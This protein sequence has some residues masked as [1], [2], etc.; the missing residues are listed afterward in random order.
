[1]VSLAQ[2]RRQENHVRAADRDLKTIFGETQALLGDI[3]DKEGSHRALQEEIDYYNPSE[4]RAAFH[5]MNDLHLRLCDSIRNTIWMRRVVTDERFQRIGSAFLDYDLDS[6]CA[7][8][9]TPVMAVITRHCSISFGELSA[10]RSWGIFMR[11]VVDS[12]CY[13]SQFGGPKQF[14]DYVDGNT[15]TSEKAWSLAENLDQRI[16][17]VGRA[18]ACGFLRGI[19]VDRYGKPDTKVVKSFRTLNLIDG[20]DEQKEAFD[21]IWH[22]ADLTGPS[23]AVID[24]ILWIAASG[25][26][27][28]TLDK[29]LAAGGLKK[30]QARRRELFR[31]LLE[32]LHG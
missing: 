5:T 17:G 20:M 14:Y 6:V 32:R 2:D 11:G 25:R 7:G 13:L 8:G 27:D 4:L 28:K 29:T 24:K 16:K 26:W 15:D 1:M 12:A 10:K 23:P 19:G 31:N 3:A 9:I 21:V 22:M 30:Q 18:L